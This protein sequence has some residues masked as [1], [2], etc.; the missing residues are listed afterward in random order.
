MSVTG[1]RDAMASAVRVELESGLAIPV[2]SIP[3]M[4][5]LKWF[6]WLD[7]GQEN[8]K[9][10]LDLVALLR[11]YHEAGNQERLYTDAL[12]ALE[13]AGYD[14]ELGGAGLLGHDAAAIAGR[15]TRDELRARLADA[16]LMDRL[17]AD[18]ARAIRGRD[19]A[20]GIARNLLAQFS[21][22]FAAQGDEPGNGPAVLPG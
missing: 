17:A 14:I 3:G 4:A 1:C 7:R 9:D 5:V 22:G 21:K 11:G 13:R 2:A 16:R 19:D 10:A 20:F 6:A 15:D 8:P 12:S 18:M